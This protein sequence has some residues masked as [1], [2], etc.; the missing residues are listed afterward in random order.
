MLHISSRKL[1]R[2]VQNFPG[3]DKYLIFLVLIKITKPDVED[4]YFT[5]RWH[6]ININTY[7]DSEEK[8]FQKI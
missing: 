2:M 4:G 7:A 8:F 6:S 1:R 5:C 3:P